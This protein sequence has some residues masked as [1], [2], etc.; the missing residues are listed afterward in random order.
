MYLS[1]SIIG[2]IFVIELEL[3]LKCILTVFFKP[4][5]KVIFSTCAR[6]QS[7]EN[8][9]GK[10]GVIAAYH[11]VA[12]T[13]HKLQWLVSQNMLSVMVF[14]YWREVVTIKCVRL[15]NGLGM[16]GVI[17]LLHVMV[18]SELKL[19]INVYQKVLLVN[20]LQLSKSLAMKML[21]QIL[22]RHFYQLGC[23][24][25]VYQMTVNRVKYMVT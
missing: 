20:K 7:K 11:V 24:K 5:K 25:K 4:L 21:A 1:Q 16:T 18:E 13:R 10:N 2:S 6:K 3:K 23:A 19:L 22:H 15:D 12:D 17:V 8:S 9:N 14:R